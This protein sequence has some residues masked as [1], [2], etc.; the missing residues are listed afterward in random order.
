[1][2]YISARLAWHDAYYV[3]SSS[4]I[5]SA[6]E[7]A[8]LGTRVQTTEYCNASTN[9]AAHML[10]A[11]KVQSAIN[12]LP[13]NLQQLGHWL[14]APLTIEEGN[15]IVEEVQEFVFEKSGLNSDDEDGYWL[16]RAVMMNYQDV[17]MNREQRLHR[18]GLI[19]EY[20]A[21]W[22]GVNIPA[23]NWSRY[24]SPK[25]KQLWHTID[26]LDAQALRPVSAVVYEYL[27]RAGRAA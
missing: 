27:N 10:M 17:V 19:R 23:N 3:R 24:Q 20:L 15:C 6:A 2:E 21:D 25:L 5:D 22:F 8:M 1:M 18:K 9:H 14:Y 12:T 7:I 11:G 16:T 4:S 13:V 26:D